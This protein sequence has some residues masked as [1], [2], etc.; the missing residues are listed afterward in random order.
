MATEELRM[1]TRRESWLYAI[2]NLGGSIPYQAYNAAVLFF[3]TDVKQLSP[4]T[5]AIIMTI[6]AIWNAVNN[7][8]IGHYSDQ[9]QSR[10]GRRIPLIKFGALPFAL[11]FAAIWNPPFDATSNGDALALWFLVSIIVFEGLGTVVTMAGHQALLPEMFPT[12]ASRVEVAVRMNW[13]QTAGL[14]TGAALP[15]ILATL[16]GYPLMGAVFALVAFAALMIGLRGMYEQPSFQPTTV[17]FWQAVRYTIANRAFISVM[18]AQMMRF[19]STNTLMAGM[20]FYIKYAI[21]AD[22]A[23]TSIVLASAFVAAGLFLPIWAKFIALRF[24]P[25]TTLLIA[26]ASIGV[27]VIPLLFASTFVESIVCAVFLGFPV[28]GLILMGDVIMADV[29][30]EDEVRTGTRREAMFYA[31]NGAAV[32]LSATIAATGFGII[33]GM[34]GYDPT[35]AVQPDTVAMGFRMYMLVLPILGAVCAVAALWFYPLHGA[36]LQALRARQR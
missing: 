18:I 12:Y 20:F 35:L 10:W 9:L 30:D 33:T 3:Y 27:A 24:G 29:I 25:R 32:A 17:P 4:A 8:I 15:P 13:I 31:V 14:F 16:I 22:P 5:A 7:P 11:S 6:Y 36:R 26:Y 19:V 28:A 23:T 1:P 34:Y 21:G 2:A